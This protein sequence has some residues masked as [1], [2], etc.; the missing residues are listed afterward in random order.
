MPKAEFDVFVVWSP[1]YS[2]DNTALALEGAA[3]FKDKRVKQYW[4]AKLEVAGAYGKVID[5]P[6]DAP[7]AYDVYFYFPKGQEWKDS[8]P[9]PKDY[10]HQ[11][12]DDGK[13]FDPAEF[14]KLIEAELEAGT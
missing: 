2:A 11:V 7:L 1:S 10:R 5:L 4:D 3:I 13:W 14:R 9:M 8:V 6:R 12:F